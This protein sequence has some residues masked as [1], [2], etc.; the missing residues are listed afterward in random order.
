MRDELGEVE[1]FNRGKEF[2]NISGGSYYGISLF[3]IR[4]FCETNGFYPMQTDLDAILRRFD[5]NANQMLDYAEYY[6]L[7]TGQE[8]VANE[9]KSEENPEE[10]DQEAQEKVQG[11]PQKVTFA[12]DNNEEPML[13]S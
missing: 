13:V 8:Y 11:S 4:L 2:E 6:E 12:Q 9:E 5:H 7:C 1:D 10:E 3:C